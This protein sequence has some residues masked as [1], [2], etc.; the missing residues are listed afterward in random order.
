MNKDVATF[1]TATP[2]GAIITSI[3]AGWQERLFTDDWTLNP[4]TY[5]YGV[6]FRPS[7]YQVGGLA[8]SWEFTDPLTLTIHLRQNVYWQNI[9][10]ANGRQFVA[11]DVIAH[12]N[13]NYIPPM[14][15]NASG[16]T[17]TSTVASWTAPDKYT[18]VL[19][20]KLV[21]PEL[22]FEGLMLVGTSEWDLENPEAVAQWG[23]LSDWHHAIGTGPFILQDYVAASS[24]TL[25]RNPNY[26]GYDE[27]YPKNQLPYLDGIKM[28]IIPDDSTALAGVRTGKIDDCDGMSRQAAADMQRS[29][30]E[31]L[32]LKVPAA[33]GL[34]IDP[35]N[36]KPFTD[37]KVREA[38]QKAIN[39]PQI[40]SNYY[41]GACDP[42]PALMT[43]EYLKG[44]SFPYAEWPQDL[45]DQFTYDP[46]AAKK[47]LA[48]AG[49]PN[50][51]NTDI[52]VDSA[53]D[54]DLLQIVK[55]EFADI[56]VNMSIQVLTPAA[57]ATFVQVNYKQDQMSSSSGGGAVGRSV[58]PLVQILKFYTYN[59]SGNYQLISDPAWDAFQDNTKTAA[60][61]DAA[62]TLV[63]NAN[64]YMAQQHFVISLLQPLNSDLYQPW[65]KGFNAQDDALSGRFGPT[66]L[67]FYGARFWIDQGLKKSMGH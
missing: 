64:Q 27:R 8:Q 26:W 11:S 32:Q 50:G 62:K 24:A 30:P 22:L 51:F 38:L 39:L 67:G 58:E 54:M 2:S 63:K 16:N 44:Y 37:I 41:M 17:V 34:S 1:D 48:D 56:N 6:T 40:A 60:T 52:V 12:M 10:P 49:F 28:L 43:S 45:K 59:A 7:N 55:S 36:V 31:I 66:F 35:K 19:K 46:T 57:W 33:F 65:L 5:N 53:Y 42:N 21:N 4:T 15:P 20:L 47:L 14:F 25:V 13:R 29:N 23:N 3:T 9:A 18:V 61:V